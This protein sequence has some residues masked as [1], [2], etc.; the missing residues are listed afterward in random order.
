MSNLEYKAAYTPAKLID[1]IL[2]IPIYQ[3]LFVWEEEQINLLLQDLEEAF[4][5]SSNTPYYIGIITVVEKDG[6]W[7]IVDGQQ[8]LTFLSLFGAY[9]C[10]KKH[11]PEQTSAWQ[12]FLFTDTLEKKSENLRINYMGRPE[13]RKDLKKIATGEDDIANRNFRIFL[14]CIKK[15]PNA[16][17]DDFAEF[18]YNHASFLITELPENYG[19]Q[20]LNLFFEKMNAT[21][22]Q[23]TAVEQ[24]KG[25]YF[26]AHAAEFDDCLNFDK[27]WADSTSSNNDTSEISLLGII[28]N[29]DKAVNA[30]DNKST[31]D[32]TSR[33]ILTPE[34]FLLHCLKISRQPDKPDVTRDERKI[35]E[36]FKNYVDSPDIPRDER[37]ILETFKNYVDSDDADK[38]SPLTLLDKMKEYRNWLDENIIYL[39]AATDSSWEYAFRHDEAKM[40]ED[41]SDNDKKMKQFQSMLYV[42]SSSFQEWVLEAYLAYPE[43]KSK[44]NNKAKNLLNLLKEQDENRHQNNEFSMTYHSIDRYWF[45]KL[46]YL[47]WE[48]FIDDEKCFSDLE[49]N[50][51]SAIKNYKFRRNRS[52][53]HLHPQTDTDRDI[54]KWQDAKH[55]FGNLAMISSSF[56][57]SQQNDSVGIKF[58]RLKEVQL[59]NNNLESIKMLLMFKRAGGQESGWT[60]DV[61]EKHQGEMFGILGVDDSSTSKESIK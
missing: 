11:L 52:I 2:N 54:D 16:T 36:T 32:V 39:K 8:R 53:E 28:L 57:S 37:K 48:K 26:P 21:G 45:W 60:V 43:W 49:D 47:L 46:D 35:L 56:N 58:Q 4:K 41:A 14:E 12:K 34:V 33:S 3:R 40:D 51:K 27:A 18:V 19:P 6:Q 44:E 23:L 30:E 15:I 42:S 24:I 17:S 22:K 1:R 5:K 25:K 20:D 10:S 55:Y 7:D 50:E 31:H 29:Y 9:C 13:D 61:M 59:R 38:I